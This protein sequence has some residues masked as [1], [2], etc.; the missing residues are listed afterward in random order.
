M[1]FR[2]TFN[3]KEE[4]GSTSSHKETTKRGKNVGDANISI[5]FQIGRRR[6]VVLVVFYIVEV[7]WIIPARKQNESNDKD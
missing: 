4:E 1:L 2:F 7:L 3:T 5:L 6:L